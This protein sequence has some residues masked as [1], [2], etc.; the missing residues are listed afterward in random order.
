MKD[1]VLEW[2][3]RRIP[4]LNLEM[5]ATGGT[6]EGSDRAKEITDKIFEKFDQ[7]NN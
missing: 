3:P 7:D 5:E 1:K 4:L 6:G 2:Y